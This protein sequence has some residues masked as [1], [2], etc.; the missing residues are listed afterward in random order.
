MIPHEAR[1]SSLSQAR[2]RA[3]EE[4]TL[5]RWVREEATLAPFY[6]RAFVEAGIE[7]RRVRRLADLEG[8]PTTRREDVIAAQRQ[9]RADFEIRPDPRII[10]ACWSFTRKLGLMAAGGR[11]GELLRSGYQRALSLSSRG[12][13]EV[14]LTS[15]DLGLLGLVGDRL[16]A[17]TGIEPGEVVL[18]AFPNPRGLLHWQ[19]MLIGMRSPFETQHAGDLEVDELLGRLGRATTLATTP[20]LAEEVL[21]GATPGSLARLRRLLVGGE[22]LDA[23]RRMRLTEQL[24]AAGSEAPV[25]GLYAPTEARMVLAE[26]PPR[27]A[28]ETS[29]SSGYHLYPDALAVELL[30]SGDSGAR[31]E[32]EGGELTIT[33]IA[34][35]G[36]ALCRYRTGDLVA[37][38]IERVPCPHCGRNLPR[39][40]PDLGPLEP[41]S[42]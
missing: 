40:G 10:R 3:L 6:Q 1:L 17:I 19:F 36:T 28:H 14:A 20:R 7:P 21:E 35:H 15:H 16:V 33:T 13:L 29:G 8:L 30:G 38:G 26:C 22:P 23:S 37:A 31:P 25:Q 12:G 2:L 39:L 9:G 11:G 18:S 5:R 27:G 41:H 24:R 42:D 4:R 34:A 32:G